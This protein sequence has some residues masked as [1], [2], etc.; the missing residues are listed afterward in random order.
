MEHQSYV[1]QVGARSGLAVTTGCERLASLRNIR[2]RS[3][4]SPY[5]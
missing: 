1:G 5:Q 2:G 4:A 3:G